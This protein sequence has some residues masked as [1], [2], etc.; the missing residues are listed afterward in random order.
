M[1][2]RDEVKDFLRTRRARLTPA[3]AGLVAFASNRRVPGLRRSEVADLAGISVEYYAQLERGDLAG[4]SDSVLESLARA[5]QLDEAERTHLADLAREA[6]PGTRQQRRKPAPAQIRPGVQRLLDLMGDTVPVI[7]NNGRLDLVAANDLGRAL[8]S[9]V[10]AASHPAG[11][12]STTRDSHSWTTAPATSG[13]TGNA[14]PMTPSPSCAPKPAATR[15]TA[16]SPTSSASSAPRARSSAP[17]GPRTTSA[18]TAPAASTSDTPS[19]VSS[20]S[21]TRRSTCPPTPA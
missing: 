2:N 11:T 9:P 13:S 6:G 16:H 5:L 18:C 1:D 3:D 17:A 20:T 8:F 7:V 10:Y 4:V 12:P 21:T 19:S 15:T 14:P